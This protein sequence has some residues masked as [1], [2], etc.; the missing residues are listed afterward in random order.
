MALTPIILNLT[1]IFCLLIFLRSNDKVIV[2]NYLSLSISVAGLI[3]LLWIIFSLKRSTKS[4]QTKKK[5]SGPPKNQFLALL[6][7]RNEKKI[8][9]VT[10]KNAEVDDPTDKD[11][12]SFGCESKILQLLKLPDGTVKVLV[13]GISRAKINS[14]LKN[15][16]YF[17]VDAFPVVEPIDD[18]AELEALGRT[19]ISQF[20]SYIKLNK[21]I[22]QV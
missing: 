5:L 14:F 15:E 12:Y 6:H 7:E 21:K 8:I 22:P 3:Q 1:I 20:E 16:D 9:L 10:Q 11:I 19:V 2:S 17:E 4:L 18:G 13:E